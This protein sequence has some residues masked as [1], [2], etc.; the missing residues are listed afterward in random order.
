[1]KN[2]LTTSNL[3]IGYKSKNNT[4]TIAENLNLNFASGKLISLI[5]ANGIGKSTLLR[6]ITGIQKPLAGHVFLKDKTITAYSPLDLAQNLSLVLTE[7]LP[8]SNLSVFELVAL[9][10]QPYTN[11]IGTLTSTDIQKVQDALELTQISDL[12]K[13]KHY[14]ISD[15]QLQKVLIARAL[16]QDTPLIILDEPTTHLD[17]LHKVSLFKLLKKLTHETNKCILFSTH[18][19]DLAIQLSDEMIIMT[20]NLVVQDEP[21]NLISKG[22]FATLFKDEHI[23]FDAEKGKFVI[24]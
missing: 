12:A 24:T 2:I 10:R 18:D 14:E 9:G 23:A 13:K 20:P 1:M 6:T 8:S 17:L 3:T 7:K 4:V 16:A 22:N 21:C 11:W 19:I 5:G 15:G